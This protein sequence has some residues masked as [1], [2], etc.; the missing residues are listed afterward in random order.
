MNPRN[1]GNR[2]DETRYLGSVG[3]TGNFGASDGGAPR[4][5]FPSAHDQ[6]T[7]YEQPRYQTE[8]QPEPEPRPQKKSGGALPILFGILLGLALIAAV[9]FF[10]L[11]RNAA[12][13]VDREPPAPVTET[14][15]VEQ[16]LTETATVTEDEPRLPTQL[17]TELPSDIL[18]S[19]LPEI[20]LEGWLDQLTGG[21]PEPAG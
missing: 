7:N 20:D 19:D 13:Q 9:I 21:E 10:F 4:Q 3:S 12:A 5:Y 6:Q 15:T 2:D 8:Y 16:T 11:W 18:P 17:P 14:M 1:P